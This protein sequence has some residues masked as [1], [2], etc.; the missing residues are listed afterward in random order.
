MADSDLYAPKRRSLFPL[1]ATILVV[2][3]VFAFATF[4]FMYFFGLFL[5]PS[6]AQTVGSIFSV[7]LFVTMMYTE[8]WRSGQQDRNLMNF[9]HMTDDKYR[10]LKAA[11][12]SQI[13]GLILAILAMISRMTEAL[14]EI[15]V[16]IF[17]LFYAPFVDLIWFANQVSP[18]LFALF[19]LITPIVAHIAYLLGYSGFRLSD[20]LF[21]RK[22]QNSSRDKKF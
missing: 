13:P 6:I 15:F 4:F 12:F 21:T 16:A 8:T 3:V 9:G 14:P 1:I 22:P 7:I 19:A 11:L 2:H 5:G 18:L 10:G 17:K 20:K